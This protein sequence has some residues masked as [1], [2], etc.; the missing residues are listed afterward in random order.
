MKRK[1]VCL[2]ALLLALC[3]LS[4]CGEKRVTVV[5][6]D[7]EV[8]TELEVSLP[9]S[10]SDILREAEI[11]LREGDRTEPALDAVLQEQREIVVLRECVVRLTVEGRTRTVTATGGTVRELLEREGLVP[12]PGQWLN[13]G[14]DEWLRDGMEIRLSARCSVEICLHGSSFVF[15]PEG[16]TVGEALNAAGI[17][18][19]PD[20]RVTPDM[21]E[22]LTD[23][24]RIRVCRM[25]YEEVR[26]TQPVRFDTRYERDESLEPGTERLQTPGV[27][28]EKLVRFRVTYAD[29]VEE[30]R[31][32]IAEEITRAPVEEVVLVGPKDTTGLTVVSKKVYYDCDGSGHGYY[33]ITYSDGSVEYIRF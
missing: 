25:S 12:A 23:G 15:A 13:C 5:I 28:G 2:L 22:P 9:A 20:D 19:G 26:E 24:M 29:G 18:P 1:I 33:E 30:S 3:L 7:R 10:V 31:E 16:K 21:N 4:G 17:V 27:D 6:R 32:L 8:S 14:E 11:V